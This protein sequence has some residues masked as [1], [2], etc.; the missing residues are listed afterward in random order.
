METGGRRRESDVV[1]KREP[2]SVSRI[3]GGERPA[4]TAG[5]STSSG[6]G[7]GTGAGA[8]GGE[9]GAVGSTAGLDQPS[10]Q[11]VRE[12]GRSATSAIHLNSQDL[13]DVPT[14]GLGESL[15]LIPPAVLFPTLS[16]E[17]DQHRLPA[18][19]GGQTVSG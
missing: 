1:S 16:S 4:S 7:E 19:F 18:P 11:E 9:T 3:A 8:G 12:V 17:S 14:A 6:E 13:P 5:G 10:R 15:R 2:V